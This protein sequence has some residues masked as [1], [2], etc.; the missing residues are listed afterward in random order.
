MAPTPEAKAAVEAHVEVVRQAMSPWLARHMNMNFA[1]TSH[2]PSSFWSTANYDRLRQIK[3]RVDPADIIRS[4]H[5]V[6]LPGG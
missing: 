4:N 3:A 6:P 5:P 1:E 2:D